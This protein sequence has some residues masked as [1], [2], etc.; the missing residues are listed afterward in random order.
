MFSTFP[1]ANFNF[2][3]II[4]LSSAN[5]FNLERSKNLSFGK[6]LSKNIGEY[7]DHQSFMI[8]QQCFQHSSPAGSLKK[9]DYAVK[10]KIER[11]KKQLNYTY[12]RNIH[13]LIS[14]Q[15]RKRKLS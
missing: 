14:S 15:I 13:V 8:F 10:V 6:E 4:K 9:R 2:R 3:Y 7:C 1:K 5:A 12:K 11:K